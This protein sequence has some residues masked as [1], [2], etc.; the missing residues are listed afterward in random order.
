[1]AGLEILLKFHSLNSPEIY[2]KHGR[3]SAKPASDPRGAGR[4]AKAPVELF[5]PKRAVKGP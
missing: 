2:V 1:M 5:T 4:F 3:V